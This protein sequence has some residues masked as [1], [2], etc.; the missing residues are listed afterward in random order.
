MKLHRYGTESLKALGLRIAEG[1]FFC[2]L[3]VLNP[4]EHLSCLLISFMCHIY[5]YIYILFIKMHA[6]MLEN[7]ELL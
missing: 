5:I 6:W 7:N 2:R 1:N 3:F 4:V